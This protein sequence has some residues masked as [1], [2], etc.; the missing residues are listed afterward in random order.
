MESCFFAEEREG[1]I[2]KMRLEKNWSPA[3]EIDPLHL[4]KRIGVD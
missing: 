2:R 3:R 1:G 4:I